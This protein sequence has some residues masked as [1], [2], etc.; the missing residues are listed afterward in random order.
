PSITVE[1]V[2]K[3]SVQTAVG[4]LWRQTTS[5]AVYTQPNLPVAG[6]AGQGD[7][8]TGAYAQLRTDYVFTPNLSGAVEAVH[9]AV[10]RTL[11]DAGG[12]DSN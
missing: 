12:D 7:R 10:G 2:D 11:R 1:P 9:Y 3:L 8:W 5:D 4:L 6:T